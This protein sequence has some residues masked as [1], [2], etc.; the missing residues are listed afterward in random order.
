VILAG[1]DVDLRRGMWEMVRSLRATGATIVL[2]TH[3]LEEAEELADRIGV[4][5]KGEIILVED[6]AALMNKL[7]KKQLALHLQTRRD[8]T[9]W[10]CRSTETNSSMPSTRK[11]IALESPR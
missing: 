10:T 6:K 9:T 3:Y 4:I 11:A 8:I 2:T 1:V 7:G 5:S